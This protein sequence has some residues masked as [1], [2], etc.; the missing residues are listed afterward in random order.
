MEDKTYKEMVKYSG[1][2]S[3]QALTVLRSLELPN[4]P[5]C[6]HVAYDFC[7][8]S[9]E[10][11]K[12]EIENLSGTPSDKLNDVQD[13][14]YNLVALPEELEM[15][16]FSRRFHQMAKSTASIMH[17]GQNQLKMY[18]NYLKEIR[19]FL[20]SGT[21]DEI[22]DV[23]TLLIKETKAVHIYAKELEHKLDRSASEIDNMKIEHSKFRE[24]ANRDPLTGMLNRAGLDDAFNNISE[25][26]ENFPVSIL[27]TDIDGFKLF[28]D[29]YGHLVGDSV[30]KVV[31]DTLSKNIKGVDIISRFGGEEFLILLLKTEPENAITVANHLRKLI[32]KL[33]IKHRKSAEILQQTTISIGI[34]KLQESESLLEAIDVAD[35]ALY[36]AKHNQKN[37]V[38]FDSK[39]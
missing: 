15:I 14:Y 7:E 19:P 8:G 36:T 34:S 28:N 29:K 23:T 38:V 27:L 37:C 1:R 13:I 3:R 10:T 24:Q 31:S 12:K 6:F 16:K 17:D 30:L 22:L 18:A 5:S 21:E 33:K 25:D 9:S 35:K 39:N 26:P 20:E 11:L 32:E 4:I 2:V